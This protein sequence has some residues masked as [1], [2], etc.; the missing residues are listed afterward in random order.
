MLALP[1]IQQVMSTLITSS[2]SESGS[3][4]VRI[5]KLKESGKNWLL[6]SCQLTSYVILRSLKQYFTRDKT[7]PVTPTSTQDKEKDALKVKDAVCY[8]MTVILT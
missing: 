4:T 5:T 2:A 3:S 7:P 8:E 6:Y 1:I